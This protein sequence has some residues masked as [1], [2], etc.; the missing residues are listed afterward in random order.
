MR[1]MVPE[2][3]SINKGIL[4]ILI[5][6][7]PLQRAGLPHELGMKFHTQ[8]CGRGCFDNP[9][10]DSAKYLLSLAFLPFDAFVMKKLFHEMRKSRF[11]NFLVVDE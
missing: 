9:V 5:A 2:F 6:V 4:S 7:I 1:K 8:K 3:T 11:Q 10:F